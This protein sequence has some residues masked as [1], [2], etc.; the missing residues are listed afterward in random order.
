MKSFLITFKPATE[1]PEQGWPIES[2]QSLVGR[3]HRGER[4]R[5]NWR[6][7]NR[8]E[9]SVGDRVF[10]L[11]QGKKGPAII[12]Y[13]EV[14]GMPENHDGRWRVEVEFESIVDPTGGV[15]AKKADL[16]AIKGAQTMWRTQASGVKLPTS[17][18]TELEAL[19]V[20]R[21]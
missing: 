21:S 15:L 19:V 12:G 8:K 17:V 3:H 10:L 6:F 1:N 4:V 2:L 16:L 20:G 11:L 13:G 5:E 9:V 18:A 7:H 14:W